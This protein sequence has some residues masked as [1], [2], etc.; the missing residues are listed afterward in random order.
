MARGA[1]SSATSPIPTFG[2][3]ACYACR[4]RTVSSDAIS[5]PR[6]A[7][8]AADSCTAARSE[9]GIPQSSRPERTNAASVHSCSALELAHEERLHLLRQFRRDLAQHAAHMGR[10]VFDRFRSGA[11]HIVVEDCFP[12]PPVLRRQVLE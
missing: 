12:H 1:K 11:E 3:I 7:S 10:D 5:R 9:L 4:R 8:A 2:A 6:T